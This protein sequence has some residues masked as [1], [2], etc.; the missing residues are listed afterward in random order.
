MIMVF[1]LRKKNVACLL[2]T[3]TVRYILFSSDRAGYA[4]ITN[5][6]RVLVA[7]MIKVY[8]QLMLAVKCR[9]WEGFAHC[10]HLGTVLVCSGCDKK[11]P[12]TRW[13][14]QQKFIPSLVLEPSSPRLRHWQGWFLLRPLSSVCRQPPSPCVFTWSSL[15]VCLCLNLLFL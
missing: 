9:G 5:N 6:Y 11:V 13:L 14:Q 8:F 10:G 15:C 1:S 12:Q 2:V 7:Y 4:A 3:S